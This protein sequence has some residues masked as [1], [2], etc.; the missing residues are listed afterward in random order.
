MALVVWVLVVWAVS[1]PVQLLVVCLW[2][3][4]PERQ[5]RYGYRGRQLPAW[6]WPAFL[7]PPAIAT[8]SFDAQLA[9]AWVD[10]VSMLRPL[11]FLLL[12]PQPVS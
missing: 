3:Q 7:E 12:L 6:L 1:L 10:M 9:S 11:L 2:R 8:L 5:W 4:V